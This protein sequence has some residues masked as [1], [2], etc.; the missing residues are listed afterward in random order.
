MLDSFLS[1]TDSARVDRTF[2][3]LAVQDTSGW[4][5]TGGVAI[6]LHILRRGGQP[7]MR[8]LHDIDFVTESFASI[9]EALGAKFLLSHVHPNDLP[10]RI[11]VQAVDPETDVRVD[12]FRAYG[13]ELDRTLPVMIG[14]FTFKMVSLQDMVA[15]HARLNWDLMESKP[16]APKYARDFLRL[17]EYV[18]T[19]EIEPIW[20]EHRKPN[21]LERFADTAQQLRTVIESRSD[22]L[23]PPTYSTDANEVC[24]RCLRAEA[25]PLTDR[26]RILSI[27]GY[28]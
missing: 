25:F 5:L 12:I 1:A 28:C 16:V 27:L 9:P 13:S 8:P 26:H 21:C 10:G 2:H 7:G 19:E 18:E 17:M 20:R 22:L 23:I 24:K 15:R 4:A 3:N 14:G 11:L 6:E